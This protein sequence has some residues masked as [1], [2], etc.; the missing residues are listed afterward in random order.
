[1][2]Q[3]LSFHIIWGR[4]QKWSWFFSGVLYNDPKIGTRVITFYEE[5]Y[6]GDIPGMDRAGAKNMEKKNK[7]KPMKTNLN[8]Q[9]NKS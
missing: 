9:A 5:Y 3:N 4:H 1:M 6:N 7:K 8:S 2:S